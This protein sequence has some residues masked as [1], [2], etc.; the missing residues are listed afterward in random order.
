MSTC[1]DN[2]F[3]NNLL[4]IGACSL[5]KKKVILRG[6]KDICLSRRC[7]RLKWHVPPYLWRLLRTEA[8]SAF[9]AAL[10]ASAFLG[11]IRPMEGKWQ[12][13]SETWTLDFP[14]LDIK[15]GPFRLGFQ[16][17]H[18]AGVKSK[19]GMFS[20]TA[21]SQMQRISFQRHQKKAQHREAAC[22]Q[23]VVC[24]PAADVIEKIV[25]DIQNGTPTCSSI[26]FLL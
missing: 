10:A 8:A 5:K 14:W 12:R 7:V 26:F 13:L 24:A 11:C 18:E 16:I 20:V 3:Q 6:P 17:C 22:G 1:L 2:M 25:S 15:Q 19:W 9:F 4:N 23:K 21:P